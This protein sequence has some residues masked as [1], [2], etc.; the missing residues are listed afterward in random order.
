MPKSKMG[1]DGQ[2]AKVDKRL[3]VKIGSKMYYPLPPP[4]QGAG[5][6]IAHASI[7]APR[8]INPCA[9]KPDGASCGPGC[10]CRGGQCYYTLFQLQKLGF[11]LSE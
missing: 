9:A 6:E 10:V 4:P 2:K 1:S 5:T 11:T 8:D 7:V 3:G